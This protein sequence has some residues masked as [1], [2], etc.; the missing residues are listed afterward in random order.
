MQKQRGELNNSHLCV[1]LRCF[2]GKVCGFCA[3]RRLSVEGVCG[4]EEAET[5]SDSNSVY[6]R[7]LTSTNEKQRCID[8]KQNDI[9]SHE[10]T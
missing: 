6:I 5:C 4:A 2:D 9:R 10:V 7:W 8:G 3:V 1:F